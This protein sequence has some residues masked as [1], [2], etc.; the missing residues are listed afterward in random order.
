MRTS[1]LLRAAAGLLLIVASCAVVDSVRGGLRSLGRWAEGLASGKGDVKDGKQQGEWTY[2]AEDG[3]VRARGGYKDDAQDGAWVYYYPN[4]DK[5][6]EGLFRDKRREGRWRYWHPSGAPRAQG[7]FVEGREQGPWMFWNTQGQLSQRGPYLEGLQVLSWSYNHP[8]GHQKAE[9][10]FWQGEKFGRWKFWDERGALQETDFARPEGVDF[11]R[12]SWPDGAR[13]REGFLQDGRK[14]GLWSS[15]HRNGQPRL[16]GPFEDG[17]STGRWFAY[18]GNGEAFASGT[19]EAGRPRGRWTL[20]SASGEGNWS[21]SGAQPAAPSLGEWSQASLAEEAGIEEV[22]VTWLAEV[23]EAVPETAIVRPEEAATGQVDAAELAAVEAEPDVPINAQPWTKRELREYEDYVA[24]YTSA[25]TPSSALSSRYSGG[26]TSSNEAAPERRGNAERAARY[27]GKPLSLHV[28]K[29]ASG[30]DFD[31][32]A[33]KGQRVVLIVLRGYAAGLCV[34]C[35][36]QTESLCDEGAFEKFQEL[37]TRLLVVFP[38]G[39]NGMEAFKRGYEALSKKELPPYEIL[40]ERDIIV[41]KLLDLSGEKVIP[42]TFILDEQG[43]VRFAYIGEDI[44]D[45]PTLDLLISELGKLEP[46]R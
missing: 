33:L 34:Y 42:S 37:N 8:D 39:K 13:K 18:R 44:A 10:L 41:G 45:R 24:A 29:S 23:S 26:S 36:A 3:S 17:H 9:G 43:I 35:T 12:E 19:V 11:A 40:Y 5:E 2:Y 6:N 27:L 31:L 7:H 16:C 46:A 20:W 15:Y 30:A 38:G 1:P 32:D 22:L 14:S 21:A 25:K 4:G 28:F